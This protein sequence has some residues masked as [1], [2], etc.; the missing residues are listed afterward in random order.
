MNLLLLGYILLN[1]SGFIYL[2]FIDQLSLKDTLLIILTYNMFI[3]GVL[4]ILHD[5]FKMVFK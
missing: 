1:M 3:F 4:L 2:K 5:V